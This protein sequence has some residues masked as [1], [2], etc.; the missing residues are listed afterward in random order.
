MLVEGS[1]SP[2]GPRPMPWRG[3]WTQAPL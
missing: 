2:P 1:A 3:G